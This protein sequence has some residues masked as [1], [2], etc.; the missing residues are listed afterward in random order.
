MPPE[1]KLERLEGRALLQAV[2]AGTAS[3]HVGVVLELANGE[4]LNLVRLGGNPFEDAETRALAGK[5]I[6]VEGYRVGHDLRYVTARE[7]R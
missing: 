7:L 5:T 2:R 4:R 3:E 1:R 6:E